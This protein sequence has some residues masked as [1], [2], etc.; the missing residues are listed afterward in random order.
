MFSCIWVFFVWIYHSRY[1][2]PPT[3]D[4]LGCFQS[5]LLQAD[6]GTSQVRSH[7]IAIRQAIISCWW[8]VLP[9]VCKN[10]A[11]VKRDK[12]KHNK[13]WRARVKLLRR[14][15]TYRLRN[16]CTDF[17]S[18]FTL[19]QSYWAMDVAL[20]ETAKQRGLQRVWSSISPRSDVWESAYSSGVPACWHRQSSY[21]WPF[22]WLGSGCSLW[23]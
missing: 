1:V 7:T 21:S 9:S 18:V 3:N 19:E 23:F 13:T 2:C 8:R 12:V 11:S 17:S 10:A 4:R 6:L 20:L 5:G 16:V 14:F 22:C 15:H